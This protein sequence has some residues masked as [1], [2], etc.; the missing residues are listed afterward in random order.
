MRNRQYAIVRLTAVLFVLGAFFSISQ[1]VAAT[2]HVPSSG[3]RVRHPVD[4]G[5]CH[6]LR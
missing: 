3:V 2:G 6:C 5:L 4:R 1:S